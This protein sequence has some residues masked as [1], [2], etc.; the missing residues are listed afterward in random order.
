M[1]V[2]IF[3]RG[4]EVIGITEP[5]KAMMTFIHQK[6]D[7]ILMDIR[8][9]HIDGYRLASM[10]RQSTLLKDIPIMMLT[11]RDGIIDRVKARMIGAVGYISKPFNPQQLV[12]SVQ[13]RVQK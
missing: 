3:E 9:P 2:L 7:L 13:D 10:L 12:Q 1:A 8:M 6:P 11:G 4:F 5:A